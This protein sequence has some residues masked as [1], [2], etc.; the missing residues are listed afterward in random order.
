MLVKVRRSS[1]TLLLLACA[2]MAATACSTPQSSSAAVKS[3]AHAST[4]I[5]NIVTLRAVAGKSELLG[6]ALGKLV[7]A[8]R[9]EP[10]CA[11][12]ELHQ[13]ADDPNLWMVYERWR[14]EEALAAHMK[15]PHVTEFL[16]QVEQLTNGAV[17]VQRFNPRP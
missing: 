11:Q 12:M 8:T 2:A 6:D 14:G 10:G 15:T 3:P 5:A 16:A 1:I 17:E 4:E 13:S 7:T 9:K